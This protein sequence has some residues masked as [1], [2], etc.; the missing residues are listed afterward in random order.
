[1]TS[2]DLNFANK[3]MWVLILLI[4]SLPDPVSLPVLK[5]SSPPNVSCSGG[6]VSIFCESVQGSLPIQYTWYEKTLS[7]D[8][9]ISDTNKLDL[10]CQSFKQQ[11]H[12]YYCTALNNQGEKT[13][14]MVNVLV[15]SSSEETCVYVT[16]IGN[17]GP[18]YFC[19]DSTTTTHSTSTKIISTDDQNQSSES[20]FHTRLIYIVFGVLGGILVVFAVSLLLY[21]RQINKHSIG[22]VCYRR[23]KSLNDNEQLVAA[24]ESTI[25]ENVRVTQSSSPKTHS[26][27]DVQFN[28]SENGIIYATVQFQ[29]KPPAWSGEVERRS[30]NNTDNVIYSGINIQSQPTKNNRKT[31]SLNTPQDSQM[32]I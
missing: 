5:F 12:Q 7:E 3:M 16:Q 24:E 22:I 26:Y 23:N 32:E 15:I 21:P 25:Y 28:N 8:S 13:S 14:E 11:H 27:G 4:C 31:S 10:H 30:L 17:I 19:E 2:A 18:E 29:K 20:K 6:S 1:M 9:K